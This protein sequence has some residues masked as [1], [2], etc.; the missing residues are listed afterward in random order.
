MTMATPPAPSAAATEQEIVLPIEGMTCASCVRR[1]E[2]AIG[3][4]EGVREIS[5][6]LAGEQASVRA[7][8]TV[9][10]AALVAA[11]ESAGYGVRQAPP[12]A[13]VGEDWEAQERAAEQGR[14][15]RHALVALVLGWSVF[16]VSQIE[17]WADLHW[18]EDLFFTVLFAVATPVLAWSGFG[19]ARLAWRVARHRS[20]DMNTLITIGVLAA[21]G[22]SVAATFAPG[23]FEAAGLTRDVFYDTALIIVGFV[24]LGRFLEARAKGRTSA[25]IKR[26]LGLRPS[27]ARVLR[28]GA[29]VE[30][31][32]D[33][34]RVGDLLIV[35]PGEKF[36]V[37]GEIVEGR[38]AVDEAM[39]T[40]ESL[41][42]E[43]DSG[44]PVFGATINGAGLLRVRA[45]QVGSGTVLAQII[46]LVES[47]QGSKAPMQRLVDAIAA[48][49]VPIVITI[50]IAALALWWAVG[51]A[52]S[53]T[54]GIINAV[55]VLVVACP[56]A[57]GLATPTAIMVGMGKGAERGVL[58]RNAEALERLHAVTTVVLDKTGTVTHGR[59]VVTDVVPADGWPPAEILRLAASVEHGSEH[60]LGRAMVTAAET[61]GLALFDANGFEAL[62]GRGVRGWVDG[63]LVELGNDRLLQERG[64][65]PAGLGATAERFQEAG[66]TAM[67]VAVDGDVRGVIAVADTVKPTA[68]A[69]VRRLRALGARTV[70]LTG[71]NA[72]TARAVGAAVG[73]DEVL[74]EV[75][76]ADKAAVVARLQRAG[77]RVA[78]VGDGIN[79]APALAQADVGIA[80]GGGADVAIE[81]AAV[82]L[83]RSDPLGIVDAVLLS[84]ATMR[85]IRQNLV[86]AFGYNVLLIPVAAGIGY[87]IFQAVGP[88]PG[89]LQWLF[90]ERGFF[91]PIVA[92]FAMMLSSLSVMANSLRLQRVRFPADRPAPPR[93]RQSPL[94]RRPPATRSASA[95]SRCG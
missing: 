42:V 87:P 79:D 59:P 45:T 73:V 41:P 32:I 64:Y 95:R 90:G 9:D 81:A 43:K 37:D 4:V 86:W 21:Y 1:V 53:L 80:M 85:T 82:T 26:L 16:F 19:I 70:L 11:V 35:R 68:A 84:R 72:V 34:V 17:R 55:A 63:R 31:A 62:P 27:T 33:D 13:A 88:V 14:L 57:L 52:P 39:L 30:I 58:I 76:P 8:P 47:A 92:A 24:T 18:D 20:S 91:E 40:G 71:D 46:A 56:C 15:F 49:F 65:T 77:R 61:Q 66:K 23:P 54:I 50:A 51:P 7:A 48:I 36:A 75:L 29:E 69:A 78:M 93:A 44:D 94:R 60:A 5:V 22:Y 2:H 3:R 6:N 74:A 28:D 67:Y 83:L 25:T 10:R 89:G 38:S 12:T